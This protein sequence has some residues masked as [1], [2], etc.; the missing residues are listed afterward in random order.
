MAMG[1]ASSRGYYSSRDIRQTAI[2]GIS[3]LWRGDHGPIESSAPSIA[4]GKTFV[5]PL[6]LSTSR[7]SARNNLFVRDAGTRSRSSTRSMIESAPSTPAGVR[8]L[9]VPVDSR[10]ETSDMYGGS[11]REGS[12]TDS[13]AESVETSTSRN[14][15]RRTGHSQRSVSSRSA[16]S[17]NG[18][19]RSTRSSRHHPETQ[20]AGL[21]RRRSFGD[22]RV[23]A[24]ARISFAFGITLIIAVVI[25][26]V[27]SITGIARNTMFHV[28][29]ILLILAL[30]GVFCHQL[31]RMFMLMRRPRGSR[32]K[33]RHRPS[34]RHHARQPRGLRN[35]P[36]E[37]C[38]WTSGVHGGMAGEVPPPEKPIQIFMASDDEPGGGDIEAMALAPEH[39]RMNP[40]FVHVKHIPLSPLTPTYDQAME[41]I[42]RNLGYRP[43]SYDSENGMTEV[44]EAQTRD[45]DAALEGIH[46]LERERMR[47][48]AAEALEGRGEHHS[49]N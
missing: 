42:Q 34:G 21:S 5:V 19:S 48:L 29:S 16:R 2:S 14:T 40:D 6:F 35:A 46:P 17:G 26:L 20:L 10:S 24:K 22:P 28:L 3:R 43:P 4:P 33:H 13:H 49:Q 44:I 25:Y 30:S 41:Q 11:L 27:L 38:E 1:R 37:H 47:T 8:P 7:S 45:V 9:S 12:Q 18:S 32:Y 36:H 15:E 31:I 39:T 23:N